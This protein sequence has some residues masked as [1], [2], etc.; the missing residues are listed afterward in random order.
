MNAVE[1]KSSA[2]QLLLLYAVDLKSLSGWLVLL[3]AV[4]CGAGVVIW[5]ARV[6]VCCGATFISEARRKL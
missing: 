4:V 3:N 6:A 5:T 2:G 1:L